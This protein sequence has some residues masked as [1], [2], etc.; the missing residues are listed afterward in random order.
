MKFKSKSL[1]LSETEEDSEGTW[2]ISYGDMVTLLLSFF[3]IFFTTDP[4]KE[5]TQKMNNLLGFEIENLQPYTNAKNS[6]AE[7]MPSNKML[8]NDDENLN[9]KVEAIEDSLV[10]TFGAVSF[11]ASGSTKLNESSKKILERFVEKYLPY[12]GSYILSIKG[13]TDKKSVKRKHRNY[14]DNLELSALRSISAMRFLRKQGIPLKRMEIAGL[15]EMN[16]ISS[17]LPVKKTLT[18]KEINAISRTLVLVIKPN[19]VVNK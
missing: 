9:I 6:H 14:K 13:F 8:L 1:S 19:Q 16:A 5:K 11:F 15:G 4:Q 2:A 3:V 18:E 7:R 17:I 10:V 12:S